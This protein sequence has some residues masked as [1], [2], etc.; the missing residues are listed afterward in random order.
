MSFWESIKSWFAP[1]PMESTRFIKNPKV[2]WVMEANGEDILIRGAIVTCFGGANDP[3]DNGDTS[4]GVSTKRH[5]EIMG[6]ALPF[7]IA[8]SACEGSPIPFFGWGVRSNGNPNP[9]GAHVSFVDEQ[10]G[11]ILGPIPAIDLGPGLHT[12]HAGDLTE[13]AA[14]VFDPRANS[15]SFER[16]LTIRI[17]GA[18]KH[19]KA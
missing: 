17:H 16:K 10:S 19:L 4:S 11:Q 5:P 15:R 8:H 3:Q 12:G 1:K 2:P 13:A 6:C 9:D 18:A 14:K 7:N